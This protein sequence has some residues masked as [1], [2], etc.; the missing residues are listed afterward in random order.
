MAW[1][2]SRP[3][4]PVAPTTATLTP[5]PVISIRGVYPVTAMAAGVRGECTAKSAVGDLDT[6]ATEDLFDPVP[7]AKLLLLQDA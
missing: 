1:S 2:R 3:T 6:I 5:S 7:A 4:A